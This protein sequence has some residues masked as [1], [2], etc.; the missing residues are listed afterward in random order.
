MQRFEATIESGAGG[1]AYVAVPA[2]IIAALR[3]GG[4]IPDRQANISGQRQLGK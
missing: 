3:G 4:R 2:E 1:G